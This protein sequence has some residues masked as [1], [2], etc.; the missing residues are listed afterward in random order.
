MTTAPEQHALVSLHQAAER[1]QPD[2][3]RLFVDW[4]RLM[5]DS[6]VPYVVSGAFALCAYTSIW[7]DTKDMDVFL[8][9]KSLKTALQIL[10]QAGYE[11]EITDTHWLAKVYQRPYFMDLIFSLPSNLVRIDDEWFTHSRPLEILGVPT[12]MVGPEELVASKVHVARSDRFD[13]ADI[14]HLIRSLEGRLDWGRLRKI[15]GDDTILLWHLLLFNFIYPG[16]TDWLPQDLMVELFDK[17]RTTWKTP[18]DPAIFFGS[19]IDPHRFAVDQER[20]D[21]RSVKPSQP[22][23][24]DKGEVL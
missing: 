7:R 6:G 1:L 21:Y 8:Q 22:L 20:W 3:A 23:V 5:N 11:T 12:R 10:S 17:V 18:G 9:P 14:A 24:N 4:L 16:H 19:A 13:G 15:L 2:Q